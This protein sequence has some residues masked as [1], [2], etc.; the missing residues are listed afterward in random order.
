MN[1]GGTGLNNVEGNGLL[2][3]SKLQVAINGYKIVSKTIVS[4]LVHT[5][6]SYVIWTLKNNCYCEIN[7]SP[8]HI[9]IA[10]LR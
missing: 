5:D 9:S 2:G 1:G 7:I 4:I 8:K 3:Q 10:R 6:Y